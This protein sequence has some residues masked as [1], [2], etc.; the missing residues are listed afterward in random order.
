MID[1]NDPAAVTRLEQQLDAEDAE[2]RARL[3]Q[4][5][6]LAAAAE[7]YVQQGVAVFPLAPGGKVPAT[8]NGFK[9]A[10]VD[11]ERVR[12]W[13]RTM[14]QANIGLP[15]GHLFDVVDVDGPPGYRSLADIRDGLP[16]ILGRVLT[17]RGGAHLYVPAS[18]RGNKAGLVAG[19]DYRGAGGYCV[20]PPSLSSTT[21]RRWTWTSPVDFAALRAVAA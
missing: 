3:E 21:G 1:W 2:R 13:W 20:A 16:P 18:G 14:P 12:A 5:G 17:A 15:T 11:L 10:T 9:D 6:A 19:V 4:P 8:R 7:W